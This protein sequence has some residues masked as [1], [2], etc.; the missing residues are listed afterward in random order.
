[1]LKFIERYADIKLERLMTLYRSVYKNVYKETFQWVRQDLL[2]FCH[3]ECF[4]GGVPQDLLLN[5]QYLKDEFTGCIYKA[6]KSAISPFKSNSFA[7]MKK[8]EYDA[9]MNAFDLVLGK[10]PKITS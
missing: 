5:S 3:E 7:V 8:A 10:R 9:S 2:D 1:M 4:H 6:R